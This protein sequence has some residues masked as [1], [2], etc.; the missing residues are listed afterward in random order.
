MPESATPTRVVELRAVGDV[1]VNRAEPDSAFVLVADELRA[2]DITYGNCE[3]VYS[4]RGE[5]NPLSRG[6]V[7]AHPRNAEAYPRAGFDVMS[8]ANN[9]HL[10]AGEEAFFDTL[11]VLEKLG[12]A[13]CGAGANLTE[14]RRPAIVESNGTRIAFLAYSSI[15]WPGYDATADSPGAAPLRVTTTYEQAEPEQ[16]G[17]PAHIHTTVFPEDLAAMVADVRAAKEIAD[18]VVLTPHWGL[19]FVPATIAEYETEVAYAAIDA[20]ADLVLG[21]HQHVVKPIQLYK[22]RAIFHGLGN[23]VIDVPTPPNLSSPGIQEMNALFDG[24]A[25]GNDPDY[26]TYPFHPIARRTVVAR[27]RIEDGRVTEVGY[28][29]CLINTKGQPA[30]LPADDPTSVEIVTHVAEI[31]AKAGFEVPTRRDGDWV[32]VP[33]E[34]TVPAEVTTT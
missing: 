4:E 29:P 27:A 8:F 26:P 11:D 13:S 15:L 25:I 23:F 17:S 5:P 30:P 32:V 14:S 1:A 22:G 21:C 12:V 3:S 34:A 31:S 16:P 18:V 6:M 24:Y 19:H 20:G 10:D 7:R 28:L 33:L 9:H 2:G